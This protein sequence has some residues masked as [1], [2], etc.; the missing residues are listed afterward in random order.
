MGGAVAVLVGMGG[1]AVL[2]AAAM[3]GAAVCATAAARV[4]A[5]SHRWAA[6]LRSLSVLGVLVG[7]LSV[8][9]GFSPDAGPTEPAPVVDL[10][11]S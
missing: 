10:R 4:Y 3:T 8:W 9:A 6:V 7:A 11:P 1:T 2:I 5:G